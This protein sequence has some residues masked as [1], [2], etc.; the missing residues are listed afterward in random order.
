MSNLLPVHA[1]IRV[2][3]KYYTSSYFC[4][5]IDGKC[6]VLPYLIVCLQYAYISRTDKA[7]PSLLSNDNYSSRREAMRSCLTPVTHYHA[8]GKQTSKLMPRSRII[9]VEPALRLCTNTSPILSQQ[10]RAFLSLLTQTLQSYF[11]SG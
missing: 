11:S 9:Y 2:G 1:W 4:I 10:L 6:K 3:Q 7:W 5:F 8:H